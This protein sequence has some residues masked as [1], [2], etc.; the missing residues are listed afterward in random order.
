M[1][2]NNS[3]AIIIGAGLAG[4]SAGCFAQI[5]GYE[6]Q[7]FEH[8]TQSGGVAAAWTR[9]EYLIDG[10]IH[11]VQG[12]K[13]GSSLY[14]LY[15]QLGIVPATRFLDLT[16]YGRFTDERS[17]ARVDM[18][19]DLDRLAADLAAGFAQ[20]DR[21]G[22][23]LV[24][25]ARALRGLDMGDMGLANP[26]ELTKGLDSL[27][28]LW[29][30]RR[31]LPLMVGK[32]AKTALD[33]GQQYDDPALRMF[34]QGL[35]LPESPMYFALILLASLA[36]GQLG[37]IEGGC[38]EFVGAMERRYQELGGRITYGASVREI[39]VERDRAVGV[40]LADDSEHRAG[41]VISAADGHSTLFEMLGGRYVDQAMAERYR[42]W[43]LY[44]P[45]LMVSYGVAREFAGEPCFQSIALAEPLQVGGEERPGMMLRLF[46]YGP[47]YS[48]PGK[49]VV[50]AEIESNWPYWESLKRQ[51][52]AGYREA[53]AQ[54]AREVLKRLE[55]HY[56]GLSSAV[57][58]TDVATPFTTWRYTRNYRA[59]WGGWLMT[60]TSMRTAFKRTLPGLA[61]FFMAGQWVMPGGGVS[62]SLYSGLHAIQL[63][64]HRDGRPCIRESGGGKELEPSQG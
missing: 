51:D 22:R 47:S 23:D 9:G 46:N 43:P 4:L 8:H 6:S 56:P 33:Y 28:D 24:N 20:G 57:E 32:Y 39:V 26:P 63:L 21:V 10:G 36:D 2:S 53:K 12:H 38:R 62:S 50:Q 58:V 30:M 27:R 19:Q 13:P 54:I 18:G 41:A 16:H 35:F 25:G 11:F 59:S 60:P 37:L 40:R 31:L 55:R 3:R 64:C 42:T 61:D 17:G 45:L 29:A 49:T 48:P 52:P 15:R 34:V 44:K 5:N 14:D 1:L 7:I